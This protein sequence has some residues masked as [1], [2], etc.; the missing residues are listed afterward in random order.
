MKGTVRYLAPEVMALKRNAAKYLNPY[1]N[2]VD[3]WAL[4]ICIYEL[5][6]E[7]LIHWSC[8]D[9]ESSDEGWIRGKIGLIRS[10]EKDNYVLRLVMG[11]TIVWNPLIRSSADDVLAL[12]GGETVVVEGK[13]GIAATAAKRRHFD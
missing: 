2:K 6:Y 11:A 1:T 13:V 7:S 12:F 9:D 8:V 4:G 5:F 10:E 3:I